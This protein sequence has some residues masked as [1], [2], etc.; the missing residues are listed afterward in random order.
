MSRGVAIGQLTPASPK[1]TVEIIDSYAN[2]SNP[3]NPYNANEAKLRV[4]A[5]FLFY[6]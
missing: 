6:T 3:S 1:N 2:A 5:V 4:L